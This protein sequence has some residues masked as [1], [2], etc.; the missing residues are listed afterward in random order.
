MHKSVKK[1]LNRYKNFVINILR[2]NKKNKNIN[3][4]IEIKN[5]HLLKN[6]IILNKLLKNKYNL[7]NQ[8]VDKIVKR[9]KE[10]SKII[11]NINCYH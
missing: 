9:V 11:I 2:R 1:E 4:N 5:I 6:L 3:I 7:I 10:I 8:N